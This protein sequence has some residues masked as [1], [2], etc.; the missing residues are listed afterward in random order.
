MFDKLASSKPRYE[1]LMAS[2][3]TTTVQSDP[4]EYRK[5]A[6]TLA[7]IEPLVAEVPRVQGRRRRA[8]RRPRS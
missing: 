6:K 5:H 7:E 4:T 2:L 1:E 3:G 8:S